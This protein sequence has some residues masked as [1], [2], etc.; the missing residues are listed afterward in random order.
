MKWIS[1]W[2]SKPVRSCWGSQ[3]AIGRAEEGKA[4]LSRDTC[5]ETKLFCHTLT[6]GAEDTQ[7]YVFWVW[8]NY[9]NGKDCW[10]FHAGVCIVSQSHLA[11]LQETR[12]PMP[13]LPAP[14]V[15]P[16]KREEEPIDDFWVWSGSTGAYLRYKNCIKIHGVKATQFYNHS[17]WCQ[18]LWIPSIII[19]HIYGIYKGSQCPGGTPARCVFPEIWGEGQT[20]PCPSKPNAFSYD[21]H[22]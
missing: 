16:S 1:R 13:A 9:Q 5:G 21:T 6:R 10:F 11:P 3:A 15:A 12:S 19:S 8:V 20:T 2:A 14:T 18:C 4:R 22:P 17:F 7:G